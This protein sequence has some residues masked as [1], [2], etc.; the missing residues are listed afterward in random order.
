M[1]DCRDKGRDK[2]PGS[3]T[4]LLKCERHLYDLSARLIENHSKNQPPFPH[5][6]GM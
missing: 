1:E 2:G 3:Y 5:F 6:P 4:Y